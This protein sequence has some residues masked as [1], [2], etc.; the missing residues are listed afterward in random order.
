MSLVGNATNLILPVN[1]RTFSNVS[2]GREQGRPTT[3]PQNISTSES[4]LEATPE[5]I[6]A[7][8]KAA[9]D[10][11]RIFNT[12]IKFEVHEATGIEMMRIVDAQT[13]MVYREIPPEQVLDMIEKLWKTIGVI[14]DTK[15]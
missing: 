12:D 8:A 15:A 13:G 5:V 1:D 9:N 6:R 10:I 2:P 14:I 4:E 3:D 7:A 11:T